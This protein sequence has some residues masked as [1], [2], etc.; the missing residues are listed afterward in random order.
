M[1]D[2]SLDKIVGYGLVAT[3][4]ISV[5]G[6]L[7]TGQGGHE[8]QSAI[9]GGLLGFLR[10]V[11]MEKTQQSKTAETL[12]KV[13]QTATQAQTAVNAVESISNIFKG[14]KE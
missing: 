6:G 4:I 5:V 3:L 13:A 7:F 2:M 14:K 1:K 10:G 8:L 11:S 9:A 12:G